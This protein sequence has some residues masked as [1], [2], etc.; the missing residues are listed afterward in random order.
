MTAPGLHVVCSTKSRPGATTVALA[1][2][3]LAPPHTR[4]VLVECD[5]AGGDL[6][7]RH[8]LSPKPGLAELAAIAADP[9][10]EDPLATCAQQI[11]VADRSVDVILAPP[12]GART[13]PAL[14]ALT[15]SGL[16]ALVRTDRTM[17]ADCGRIEPHGPTWPLLAAAKTVW[18]LTRGQ[19]EELA[20][21]REHAQSL[22]TV[23]RTVV[24]LMAGGPHRTDDVAELLAADGHPIPV[25]GPL[26]HDPHTARLLAGEYGHGQHL[27]GRRWL[28]AP[29]PT[30]LYACVQAGTN[31]TRFGESAGMSN[32]DDAARGA[33][34]NR[35]HPS[36]APL[37]EAPA[38]ARNPSQERGK[39]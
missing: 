32:R 5:P 37:P 12:G 29:L 4:P 30:A 14:T 22:P 25:H 3:A 10:G 16:S 7:V 35:G 1:L 38:P 36:R 24:L 23:H 31:P 9:T 39:S 11:T 18:L 20:H 8:G 26:P 34:P 6:A 19:P 15:G 27:W 28:R 33:K 21:L 2:A 17:I 13:R